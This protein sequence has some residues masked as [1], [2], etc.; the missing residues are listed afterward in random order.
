MTLDVNGDQAMDLLYELSGNGGIKVSLGSRSEP[1]KWTQHDF[2]R[3][4]VLTSAENPNCK[5]PNTSDS[6]SIP[7][8]NAFLDLN[9][10]CLPEIVLTR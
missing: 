2:F 9:G 6:L 1:S 10:D 8:S 5:T 3:N 7:D 4:Y